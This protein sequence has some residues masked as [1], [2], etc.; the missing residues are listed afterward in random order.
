M[1]CAVNFTV[2][3]LCKSCN[4]RQEETEYHFKMAVLQGTANL[5]ISLPYS[6]RL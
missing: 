4:A 6:D 5:A 1:K 3:R 2:L